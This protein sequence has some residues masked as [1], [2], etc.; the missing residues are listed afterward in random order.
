MT[1]LIDRVF[2]GDWVLVPLNFLKFNVISGQGTFYGSHVWHWYVSQG[3][4]VVMGSQL[5]LFIGGLKYLKLR[6]LV[7]LYLVVWTILIYRL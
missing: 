6:Q 5:L 4:P 3:F 1:S 7:P 2:Y